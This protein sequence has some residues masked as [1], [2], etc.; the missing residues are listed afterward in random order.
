M[1]LETIKFLKTMEKLDTRLN[2]GEAVYGFANWLINDNLVDLNVVDFRNLIEAFIG[3]N[4]LD[5]PRDGWK[6]KIVFPHSSDI[7]K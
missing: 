3:A 5:I 4:H 1:T 2:S 6:R 7:N